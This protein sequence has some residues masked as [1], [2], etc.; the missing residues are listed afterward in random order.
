MI[1]C[2]F[3]A[4]LL[5]LTAFCWFKGF[6]L[7]IAT[8]NLKSVFKLSKGLNNLQTSRLF[9]ACSS[10]Q[11]T[12]LLTSNEPSK[13]FKLPGKSVS[14]KLFLDTDKRAVSFLV[15][16]IFSVRLQHNSSMTRAFFLSWKIKAASALSEC[17]LNTCNCLQILLHLLA[18]FFSKASFMV[19][20][21][22][23]LGKKILDEHK[24]HLSQGF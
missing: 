2:F 8:S 22:Q 12:D 23:V 13:Y 15:S 4:K 9:S 1:W 17:Y 6:I 7:Q 5:L 19:S 11:T 18:I 16:H 14:R 10:I 24:T 20:L 21:I 3:F